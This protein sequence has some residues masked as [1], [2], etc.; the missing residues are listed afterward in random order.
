MFLGHIA[1]GLAGKRAAPRAPLAL[2]VLAPLFVDAIWPLFL[3][4]GFE[5]VHIEPGNTAVTPL[6]FDS[7]PWTHSLLMGLVWA[8]LFAWLYH[9][10][11]GDRRSALW[12][13]AAVT[14]HWFLDLVVHRPD[15][16]L[17]PGGGPKLGFGVWNHVP[18]T[19]AI[20][21]GLLLA[22]TLLYLR[23]ARPRGAQGF[24]ALGSFLLFLL[25]L[26]AGVLAGPPPP[27]TLAVAIS[28]IALWILV[29]WAAWID[30]TSAPRLA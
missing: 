2:L 23:A 10:R 7:Y 20:E 22:G 26:Y 16:P 9:R 15:L 8:A 19:I 13:G 11:G 14:S 12:L 28:A 24:L 3:L 5:R 6:A 17:A 21:V 27:N 4:A 25:V 29:P 1:V 30:H 18:L